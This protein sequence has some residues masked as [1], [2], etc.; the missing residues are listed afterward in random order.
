MGQEVYYIC[1]RNHSEACKSTSFN[2]AVFFFHGLQM[3]K[4][5]GQ[6]SSTSE[7]TTTPVPTTPVPAPV[8]RFKFTDSAYRKK[9]S[10]SDSSVKTEFE[11]YASG[12]SSDEANIL[13]FWE[14]GIL[15]FL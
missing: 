7:A 5:R 14:V 1:E 4:Y 12:S 11:R 6:K 2:S 8:S 13:G 9:A 10:V 3:H 15:N